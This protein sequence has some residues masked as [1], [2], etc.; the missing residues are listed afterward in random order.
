[1]PALRAAMRW[2]LGLLFVAA[3]A[4]HFRDPGFYLAMMPPYLPWHL[5][6]VYIS[7]IAEIA[8]GAC[9]LAP[10]FQVVAAWG[11]IALLVAVFPANVN[12]AVSSHL[13][14][15]YPPA[16]LWARLPMQGVLIAWAYWFTG[17]SR[18]DKRVR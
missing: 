4:N 14:P 5:P 11:I 13:F 16:V 8:L 3:G 12:M 10:K 2:L 15:E 17:K 6:L 9:L 18:R 1:M 7:G